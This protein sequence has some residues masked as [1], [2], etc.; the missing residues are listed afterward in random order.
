[1]QDLWIF[2]TGKGS[3]LYG[4]TLIN[5]QKNLPDNSVVNESWFEN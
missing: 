2:V 1:M 4:Q 5:S 3:F